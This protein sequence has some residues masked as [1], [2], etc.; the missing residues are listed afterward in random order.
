M[1]VTDPL[2]QQVVADLAAA[3]SARQAVGATFKL[4]TCGWVRPLNQLAFLYERW[5]GT[6]NQIFNS[7]F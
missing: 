1:P 6:S 4:A 5:A 7:L 2:I 3:H